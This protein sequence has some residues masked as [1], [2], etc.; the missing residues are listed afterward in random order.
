MTVVA[1]VWRRLRTRI[2]N[3]ARARFTRF[4]HLAHTSFVF[5]HFTVRSVRGSI[6]TGRDERCETIGT[7]GR[8]G[9]SVRRRQT[10]KT[11]WYEMT[12]YTDVGTACAGGKRVGEMIFDVTRRALM[13]KPLFFMDKR[14]EEKRD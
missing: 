13:A 4:H 8:Y 10:D 7:R 5:K 3:N 2:I 12:C 14:K 11:A 6:S 9:H 1:G